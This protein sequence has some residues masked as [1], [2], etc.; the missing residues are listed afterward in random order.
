MEWIT[1]GLLFKLGAAPFHNWLADVIDGVATGIAAWLAVLSKISM[2]M[3]LFILYNGIMRGQASPRI[4][5][6]SIILSLIVGSL[7]GVV[8]TRIKPL[9]AYSSI[10]H[11]GYILIGIINDG[12]TCIFYVVQ[13]SLTI[14]N[15]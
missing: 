2:I 12:V 8:Q 14:I 1:V 3:I 7:V 15:I 5:I 6:I 11:G 10:A 9:L 13:Y 4:I